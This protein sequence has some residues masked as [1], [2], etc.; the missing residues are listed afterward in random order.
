MKSKVFISF[1]ALVLCGAVM[2]CFTGCT[3]TVGAVDLCKGLT[4]GNV[5]GLPVDDTFALAQMDFST[6]LF[7]SVL[8][9]K[10]GENVMV[11]PLSVYV[12]LSILTNGAD[13]ETLKELESVLAGGN[14]ITKHNEY[15]YTYLNGLKSTKNAKFNNSNSI[16][17]REDGDF[18]AKKE[19]LQKNVDYYGADIFKSPFNE[20]TVKDV[21]NWVKDKTDGDID[22]MLDKVDPN[23]VMYIINALTFDAEWKEKYKEAAVRNGRFTSYSKEEKTVTMMHSTEKSYIEMDNATGF[24]KPYKENYSLAVLLPDMDVDAYDFV[25]QLDSKTLRTAI[26]GAKE[27]EV[28]A[29]IPKFG[30]D[31]EMELKQTLAEM[32]MPSAFDGFKANFSKVSDEPTYVSSVFQKTR[33]EV[34][35]E[36]TKAS[37]TTIV[38]S[39]RLSAGF[40]P[41]TVICDRPFVFM[42][43]DNAEKLPIFMGVVAGVE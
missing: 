35:E 2:L 12:A 29:A 14:D 30:F 19:F 17:L 32:G 9:S 13:G 11:S 40:G 20:D 41:K 18:V 25:S 23:D 16:W 42:I 39:Q 5:K 21:N 1:V 28:L 26:N 31:S 3:T 10:K 8:E 4:K 22:K 27:T 6:E 15:L 7:K 37:A 38:E 36:G 33:I 24:I 43:I 34:S